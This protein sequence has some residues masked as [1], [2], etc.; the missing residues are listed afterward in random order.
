MAAAIAI[1]NLLRFFVLIFMEYVHL[2][3]FE[4]S[5]HDYEE[6]PTSYDEMIA[7]CQDVQGTLAL[8]LPAADA[9]SYLQLFYG[10]FRFAVITA[11]QSLTNRLGPKLILCSIVVAILF[12]YLEVF[13]ETKHPTTTLKGNSIHSTYENAVMLLMSLLHLFFVFRMNATLNKSSSFLTTLTP[14]TTAIQKRIQGNNGIVRFNWSMWF[15]HACR[16]FLVLL[17][18]V[19]ANAQV[20]I[21]DE[22]NHGKPLP[23]KEMELDP[24]SVFL[25]VFIQFVVILDMAGSIFF[26]L[27]HFVFLPS[28]QTKFAACKNRIQGLS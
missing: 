5:T 8:I 10:I 19:V 3:V 9:V 7:W 6:G 28:F 13:T 14:M 2:F 20:V 11:N 12:K 17:H 25:L 15:L 26:I 27:C 24:I 22:T 16:P 23:M 21:D 18:Y 1:A 4:W